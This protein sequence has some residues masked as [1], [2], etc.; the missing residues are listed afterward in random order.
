M[1]P[2]DQYFERLQSRKHTTKMIGTI[3][4]K[5]IV[6]TTSA[7]M[8]AACIT[9]PAEM[10]RL[11]FIQQSLATWDFESQSKSYNNNNNNNKINN[12]NNNNNKGQIQ[13]SLSSLF[14]KYYNNINESTIQEQGG[15]PFQYIFSYWGRQIQKIKIILSPLVRLTTNELIMTFMTTTTSSSTTATNTTN[16]SSSHYNNYF[17]N[18][19]PNQQQRPYNYAYL[20]KEITAG[21]IAGFCQAIILCP[22][23]IYRANQIMYI[24]KQEK[25][26]TSSWKYWLRWTKLQLFESGIGDPEERRNRAL[27][28]IGTLALREMVFNVSFFPL[29]TIMRQY[30]DEK[31]KRNSSSHTRMYNTITSGVVS[32]LICSVAVTPLDVFKTYMLYSREQW[33]VWTGKNVIGPPYSLLFR[34]LT[35]QACTFGPS[36]GIVAAIYELNS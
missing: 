18:V 1:Y 26:S 6:L 13:S 23:E 4:T 21:A 31:S 16:S 27:R 7:C 9:Y 30:L 15:R 29:F 33:S 12:N 25:M 5:K 22:L 10:L 8:V 24:E 2:I 11:I 14:R 17:F 20:R 19:Y 28:A 32:G 35:I 3:T 34:G 36:F